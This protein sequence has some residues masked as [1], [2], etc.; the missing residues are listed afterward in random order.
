MELIADIAGRVRNKSRL[1]QH[2]EVITTMKEPVYLNVYQSSEP[3][4][5]EE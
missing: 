2:I 4:D 1:V 5:P 3:P